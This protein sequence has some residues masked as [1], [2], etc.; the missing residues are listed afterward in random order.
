[1]TNIISQIADVPVRSRI[2]LHH[3]YGAID[4][5]H[6]GRLTLEQLLPSLPTE[7]VVTFDADKLVD[8]RARRPVATLSQ[9]TLTDM[10]PPEIAIDKVTDYT[11]QEILVLHGPEPDLRW[12]EFAQV[13]SEYA[14]EAGIET[15]INVLGLPAA[16]PH[17]RPPLVNQTGTR[18]DLLPPQDEQAGIMQFSASMG[19][20]LQY[21]L[22][23][24]GIDSIGLTVGVPYYVMDADYPAGAA[25]LISRISDLTGLELPIGDLEAASDL[26]SKRL[27]QE[28]SESSEIGGVIAQLEQRIDS[29]DIS[30]LQ[31][32]A[33]K[34]KMPSGEDLAERLEDFLA[35]VERQRSDSSE[36]EDVK[37]ERPR[38]RHR[39]D[40]PVDGPSKSS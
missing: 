35:V 23:Q 40:G 38:G 7:R 12:N 27:D 8:F 6:A 1:M 10:E 29:L 21:R 16:T 39:A 20:Y 34:E 32:G 2:L 14:K 31:V 9:W 30:K 19:M 5:G 18:L 28:A 3:M 22:G 26:I 37:E 15:A 17:T 33:N 11:G 13:V 4:A 36:P 24:V 25:A